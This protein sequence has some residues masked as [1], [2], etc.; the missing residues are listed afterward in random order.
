LEVFVAVDPIEERLGALEFRLTRCLYRLAVPLLS[1]L[2]VVDVRGDPAGAP[3]SLGVGWSSLD[4][5]PVLDPLLLAAG[6]HGH[7][8]VAQLFEPAGYGLAA[9]A[10]LGAVH[11][12]RGIHV[13]EKYGRQGVDVA[14]WDVDG[15]RKVGVGIEA[16]T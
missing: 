16:D 12:D 11:D 3:A 2:A 9:R 4:R 1:G 13:R 5:Q 10:R 6:V 7:G 14:R 15:A 8:L